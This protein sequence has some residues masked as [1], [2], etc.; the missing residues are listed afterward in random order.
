MRAVYAQMEKLASADI[1]TFIQGENG[2]GKE[3]IARA[4]HHSGPRS[5]QPFVTLDCATIAEGLVESH[6]FGHVRGAFTGAVST[7]VGVFAQAHRGTLFIDEITELPPHL[8]A[9]LLR[10]I[11]SG[12]FTMVGRNRP[13]RADVRTITATNQ[14]LPRAVAEGRFREDL[15]FRIAVA[16]IELPPLRERREDVPLLATHFLH[17]CRVKYGRERIC[18]LTAR[19]MEALIAYS[20]PGNVRQLEN[21]IENAVILAENEMID[22][23]HF[24]ELASGPSVP[25][26]DSLPPGLTLREFERGYIVETLRRMG[27]DRARTARAL[28]IS[29][30]KLQYRLSGGG[31]H[32][33]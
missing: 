15:Y 17:A 16:R 19:G 9:R 24:P 23:E 8:Q 20:W 28:G 12:E 10:V 11:A 6:L 32:R 3:L 1:K 26:P 22:L 2:T 30:R 29:V 27:G 5:H 18:G 14:D 7:R 33:R 21:W 25:S 13:E 4:L 31:S